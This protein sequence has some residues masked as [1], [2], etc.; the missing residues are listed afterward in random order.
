MREYN[1]PYIRIMNNVSGSSS[2]LRR[3]YTRVYNAI[4]RYHKIAKTIYFCSIRQYIEFLR[5]CPYRF[6]KGKSVEIMTH[7]KS[8]K[9][10]IIIDMLSKKSMEQLFIEA[11]LKNK[12][13]SFSD[14]AYNRDKNLLYY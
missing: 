3:N 4:L 5:K 7:P 11:S 9:S 2:I 6:R 14:T 1:I 8:A 10:G 12:A 13:S